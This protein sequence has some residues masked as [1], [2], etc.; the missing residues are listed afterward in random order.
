MQIMRTHTITAREAYI[1]ALY[2]QETPLQEEIR[3][4]L[5]GLRVSIHVSPEEGKLL[6]CLAQMAGAAHVV[7]IGTL[8]GYSA[9]WLAAALPEHGRVTSFEKNPRYVALA[10]EHIARSP[11]AEKIAIVEGDAHK[12]LRTHSGL[13]DLV[14]IDAEKTGYPDYLEWAESVLKPGGLLVA[15]NT[16]LFDTVYAEEIPVGMDT[17]MWSAMREFNAAIADSTRFLSVMIPTSEGLTVALKR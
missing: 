13:V 2:A 8:G 1:R 16:L 9:L 11:Y 4:T 14:F 15:D 5:A 3:A 17:A 6:Q 10:R 7:E 12:M